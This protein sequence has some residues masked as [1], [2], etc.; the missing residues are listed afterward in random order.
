MKYENLRQCIVEM[1][2]GNMRLAEIKNGFGFH[3]PFY[4]SCCV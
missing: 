2:G 3:L 1:N 4:Y